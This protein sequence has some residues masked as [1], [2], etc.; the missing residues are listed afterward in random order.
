MTQSAGSGIYGQAIRFGGTLIAMIIAYVAW[1][2]TDAHVAGIIVFSG[3]AMFLY[4]FPFIKN[5][6]DPVIPMIGKFSYS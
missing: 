2:I 5:P 1:Y 6:A 3:I 4:H